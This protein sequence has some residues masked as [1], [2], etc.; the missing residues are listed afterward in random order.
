MFK[1]PWKVDYAKRY[2][3]LKDQEVTVTSQ[4]CEEEYHYLYNYGITSGKDEAYLIQVEKN[5]KDCFLATAENQYGLGPFGFTEED[6]NFE[7][8][9]NKWITMPQDNFIM[10]FGQ[11]DKFTLS[12]DIEKNQI[13]V[14][15]T[16]KD[17]IPP[18]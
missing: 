1:Y 13:N 10:Q 3:C 12:K 6:L 2:K 16:N 4:F 7:S 11:P 14:T 5:R 18:A 15:Y 9:C 17:F 8:G